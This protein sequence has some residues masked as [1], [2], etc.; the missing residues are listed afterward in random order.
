MKPLKFFQVK[1]I[2]I[3]FTYI[4]FFNGLESSEFKKMILT[5]LASML[6]D[7]EIS[8]LGIMYNNID[9]NKDGKLS[10]SE[11]VEGNIHLSIVS[12]FHLLKNYLSYVTYLGL[13]N[14]TKA[15]GN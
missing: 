15:D 11:L 6:S 13:S 2:Q 8:S 10:I 12:N 4:F 7:Y 14:M 1:F 5:M 3:L 9:T